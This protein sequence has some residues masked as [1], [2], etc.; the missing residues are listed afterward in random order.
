MLCNH[1]S[2]NVLA[3][4]AG[5]FLGVDSVLFINEK[6]TY[7][8]FLPLAHIYEC[9]SQVC[10]ARVRLHVRLHTPVSRARAPVSTLSSVYADSKLQML[11][12]FFSAVARRRRACSAAMMR[13]ALRR[14]ATH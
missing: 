11:L 4:V 6:D 2:Q 8:S 14:M 3:P 13:R 12:R 7:M 10:P 9:N 5:M 1:V